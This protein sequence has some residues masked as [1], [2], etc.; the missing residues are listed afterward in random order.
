MTIPIERT[1]AL[2]FGW[3]LLMELQVA[4]NVTEKQ[5]SLIDVILLHYPTGPEIERWA[6]DRANSTMLAPENPNA[7]GGK[8]FMTPDIADTP[9]RPTTPAQR[10]TALRSAYEFFRFGLMDAENLTPELKG[11][12]PYVLR[13]FPEPH[14][15]GSWAKSDDWESVRDPSIKRW[16]GL[17]KQ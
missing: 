3:E 13:H 16:L 17:E 5:R 4:D 7:F 6:A 10:T 11:Q 1:R 12:I 9:C 8:R 15:L 2:R 14:E